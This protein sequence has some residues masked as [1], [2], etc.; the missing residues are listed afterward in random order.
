M[1]KI[2]RE[3]FLGTYFNKDTVLRLAQA[4]KILAWIILATYAIQLLLSLGVNTL[5]ILRG[6]WVGMG[7]TDILQNYLYSFE[8]PLHG[9]VYSFALWGISQLLLIFLDIEDNTRG[10]ARGMIDR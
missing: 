8:Q 2:K 1:E 3:E 4:L 7:F 6:F 5:Q 9:V 10:A